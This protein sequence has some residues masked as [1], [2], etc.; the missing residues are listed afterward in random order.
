MLLFVIAI[1]FSYSQ[2]GKSVRDRDMLHDVHTIGN[3]IPVKSEITVS[4]D[5]ASTYVLQCYFIRYFNI[6]LFIEKPKEYL[7]VKKSD[8]TVIP[9]G[10]EKLLLETKIYDVFKLNPNLFR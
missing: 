3:T 8:E 5:I 7:M 1:G 6:S 2:K 10:Y 9:N 4:Q